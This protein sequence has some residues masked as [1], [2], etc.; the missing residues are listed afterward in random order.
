MNKVIASAL[1][2]DIG[3][4]DLT[5]NILIN[6]KSIST[7][8]IITREECVVSGLL[9][10]KKVFRKLDKNLVYH[11]LCK[12][13]DKVPA[14]TKLVQIRG[15][16][17]AI[18]TGERVALNFLS[19]M[20]GIATKTHRFVNKVRP[21]KAKIFDTRKT[22][23]GLRLIK[24]TAV[25]NGGGVNHRFSLNEMVLI[26]DNHRNALKHKCSLFEMV[27]KVKRSTRKTIVVEVEDLVQ[28]QEVLAGT[29]DVILLD[30]MKIPQI[31]TAVKLLKRSK[32]KR[33]PR[34]EVSGCVNLRNVREIA[35][36]GVD[37]ISIGSLTHTTKSIDLSL[38]LIV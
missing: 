7:A 2:E 30:N 27:Q 31:R 38:E 36:S 13:G 12:D 6:K 15:K 20:S 22:T 3:R 10:A 32:R 34:L 23:P 9:V 35:K 28:F 19:L 1:K 33:K 8:Y 24:K 17:R 5:T 4:H 29:P 37:R 14:N 11:P 26:K 25:R 18:L 21:Y 16:T